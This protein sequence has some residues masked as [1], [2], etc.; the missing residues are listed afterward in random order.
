M[1]KQVMREVEP[2]GR[3]ADKNAK[4]QDVEMRSVILSP[5]LA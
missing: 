2:M 3:H 5:C 1:G 4:L